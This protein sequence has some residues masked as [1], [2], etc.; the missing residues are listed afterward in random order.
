MS[1]NI[2]QAEDTVGKD[3]F[4]I[5]II[6]PDPDSI[7][8]IMK[9]LSATH[10]TLRPSTSMDF[11]I[12]SATVS[13]PDL[14][15]ANSKLYLSDS[16]GGQPQHIS[17]ATAMLL[18]TIMDNPVTKSVPV[19]VISESAGKDTGDGMYGA[20]VEFLS[21]DFTNEELGRLVSSFLGV[22]NDHK[23]AG[24]AILVVDDDAALVELI[25]ELIR[26]LGYKTR[27][28]TSP[29]EAL[30]I[31]KANPD[32]IDLLITDQ[33]MP[34]MNGITLAREVHSI[35]GN[36]PVVLLSGYDSVNENTGDTTE[37]IAAFLQKPVMQKDLDRIIREVLED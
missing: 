19:I 7:N 20:T 29:Q 4:S 21:P 22:S 26:L 32:S 13:P 28:A 6:D 8:R 18:Q 5:I 31:F 35:R 2:L 36:L 11:A 34:G 16:Q 33:T 30:S 10:Y 25:Q 24:P 17:N 15:I 9:A 12:R 1:S 27:G 3:N 37:H 23:V 14:I